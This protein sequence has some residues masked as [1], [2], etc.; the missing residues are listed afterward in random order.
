MTKPTMIVRA[1]LQKIVKFI[2]SGSVC[3]KVYQTVQTVFKRCFNFHIIQDAIKIKNRDYS[4]YLLRI[5]L[6]C[7]KQANNYSILFQNQTRGQAGH[8]SANPLSPVRFVTDTSVRS[9]SIDSW[10]SIRMFY[11]VALNN[12][13]LKF[14]ARPASS[15]I[16]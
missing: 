4:I 3:V 12:K 2:L 8:W 9:V 10:Y 16:C 5:L 13:Q 6:F 1:R 14:R 11:K 7:C 15:N